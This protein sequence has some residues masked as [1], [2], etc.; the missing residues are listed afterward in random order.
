MLFGGND[1]TVQVL[2]LCDCA[3]CAVLRR[4]RREAVFVSCRSS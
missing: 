3:V 2:F 4:V 1:V